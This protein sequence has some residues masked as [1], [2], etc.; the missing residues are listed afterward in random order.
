MSSS[1]LVVPLMENKVL[2]HKIITGSDRPTEPEVCYFHAADENQ[3]KKIAEFVKF[4]LGIKKL[5]ARLLSDPGVNPGYIE[6]WF[7]K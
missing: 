3:A 4:K 5:D 1:A 2:S 6:I 7:G